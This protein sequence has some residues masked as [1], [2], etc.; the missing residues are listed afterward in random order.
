MFQ[1]VLQ[2]SQILRQVDQNWYVHVT[3]DLSG[4]QLDKFSSAQHC[5]KSKHNATIMSGLSF[6]S[7]SKRLHTVEYVLMGN[8]CC[9]LCS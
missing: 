8:E 7:S 6:D 4:K 9:Q 3:A 2:F 1:K 5:C